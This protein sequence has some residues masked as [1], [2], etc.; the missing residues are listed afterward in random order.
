MRRD[1]DE[2]EQDHR[3]FGG[4]R[5]HRR[6]QLVADRDHEE[7]I[8]DRKGEPAAYRLAEAGYDGALQHQDEPRLAGDRDE[9]RFSQQPEEGARADKHQARRPGASRAPPQLRPTLP[10]PPTDYRQ[11]HP[12][13]TA[14]PP[15]KPNPPPPPPPP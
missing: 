7:R 13:I 14:G 15:G 11:H 12:A 3:H 4:E 5:L 9:A 6:H 8:E 10:H 2:A 1:V